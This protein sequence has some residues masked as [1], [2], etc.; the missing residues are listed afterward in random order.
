MAVKGLKI[1]KDSKGHPRKAIF[2]MDAHGNML[3]DII[4][5]LIVDSKINE[6]EIGWD[7]VK[8]REDKRRKL[9]KKQ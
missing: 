5:N 3:E 9:H 1:E 2:N 7:I 4:D 8:A 6:E